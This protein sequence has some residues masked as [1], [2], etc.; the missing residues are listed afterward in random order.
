MNCA[1]PVVLATATGRTEPNREKIHNLT[2]N[3]AKSPQDQYI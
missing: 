2:K 1:D 3:L